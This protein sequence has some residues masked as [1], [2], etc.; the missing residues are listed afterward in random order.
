MPFGDYGIVDGVGVGSIESG[1][2]GFTLKNPDVIIGTKR[3]RCTI[4]LL[5][6]VIGTMEGLHLLPQDNEVGL[7]RQFKSKHIAL[8][9]AGRDH[10]ALQKQYGTARNLAIRERDFREPQ[11]PAAAFTFRSFSWVVGDLA[12]N[13]V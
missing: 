1:T 11:Q 7:V 3:T 2:T 4:C 13:R 10:P 5:V 6:W 8:R 12:A 9:R